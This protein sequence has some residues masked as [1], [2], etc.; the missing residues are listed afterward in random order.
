MKNPPSLLEGLPTELKQLILSSISDFGTLKA[1]ALSCPSLFTAFRC[2][3]AATTKA[4]LLNQVGPDILPEAVARLESSQLSSPRTM[5]AFVTFI[6]NHLT[7]RRIPPSTFSFADASAIAHFHNSVAYFATKCA[8]AIL[9]KKDS[10]PTTPPTTTE[11]ARFCR[12][13]YRFQIYNDLYSPFKYHQLVAI[14]HE[15]YTHYS[16]WENEQLACIV[17]FI[18]QEFAP[19]DMMDRNPLTPHIRP[20]NILDLYYDIIMTC[21]F[22]EHVLSFNLEQLAL[23]GKAPTEDAQFQIVRDLG[24]DPEQYSRIFLDFQS[25][26]QSG[27]F[28]G[29]AEFTSEG[30]RIVNT[31]F[32]ADTDCGPEEVW[33]WS[34]HGT[35]DSRNHLEL[36]KWGY[37]FWDKSRLEG[38]GV[39]QEQYRDV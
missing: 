14:D 27:S 20:K 32:Y 6:A 19:G 16:P 35:W 30:E 10:S 24:V 8:K 2:S 12:A 33:R 34:H 7:I 23:L 5:L 3:V 13:F 11:I 28:L 38:W 18:I 9:A 29:R 25:L 17:D 31:P 22:T 37:V 1:A 36:R 26:R 15:F 21:P 39:F 4:V